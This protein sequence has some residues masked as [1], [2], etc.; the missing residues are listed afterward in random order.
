MVKYANKRDLK[1]HK[2]L[3]N[4]AKRS[5]LQH[6]WDAYSRMKNSLLK[7]AHNNYYRRL[8]D[9]SFSGNH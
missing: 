3:Y 5:N 9:N 7:E 4:K 1:V 2:R 8:F 6:D